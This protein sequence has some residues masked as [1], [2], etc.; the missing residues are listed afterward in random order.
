MSPKIQTRVS[1][2]VRVA[3][4]AMEGGRRAHA[5]CGGLTG[6]G[7]QVFPFLSYILH[8]FR[9]DLGVTLCLKR[10]STCRWG[11]EEVTVCRAC[12]LCCFSSCLHGRKTEG[13]LGASGRPAPGFPPFS[14]F[15]N[16]CSSGQPRLQLRAGN[17]HRGLPQDAALSPLVLEQARARPRMNQK[18]VPRIKQL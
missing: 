5:H 18:I 17:A 16:T 8:K 1:L 15:P 14:S 6:A 10:N 2:R 7:R 13:S 11:P 4:R 9:T 3:G 12:S